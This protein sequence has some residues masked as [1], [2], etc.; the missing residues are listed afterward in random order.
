MSLRLRLNLLVAGLNLGFLMALTWL[1]I[2]SHR[3]KIQ[4]E[5]E[6]AHRVTVPPAACHQ[7]RRPI[8]CDH[9]SIFGFMT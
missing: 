8:P 1:L 7:H 9:F 3:S 5:V 2:D 6:A 4:E